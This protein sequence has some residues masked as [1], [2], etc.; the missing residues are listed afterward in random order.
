MKR[1]SFFLYLLLLS[2]TSFSQSVGT[3]FTVGNLRY[4]VLSETT[5][6]VD[7][8]SSFL[9]GHVS[10]PD[11]VTYNSNSFTVTEIGG[12]AF[13]NTSN[14]NIRAFTLPRTV[15]V[16]GDYA[17][18]GCNLYDSLVV[19]G[20]IASV[21]DNVFKSGI[22]I[23]RLDIYDQNAWW[24]ASF[25][26]TLSNPICFCRNF[27]SKGKP[28]KSLYINMTDIPE[29]TFKYSDFYTVIIG[30][31]VK[32]I[33]AGSF[34]TIYKTIWLPN[35]VPSGNPKRAEGKINHCSST[36]YTENT[37][38]TT[39]LYH[40]YP[41]LTSRFEV[42]GVIYA[43]LSNNTQCDVIDC[44]YSS[45]PISVNIGST[46]TYRGR[47]FN[48]RNIN[49]YACYEDECIT[50]DITLA[51]Q[52]DV[53]KYAFYSCRKA[54]GN[55]HLTNTGAIG[56]YAF[57]Y[58]TNM[59]GSITASNGGDIG[60]YAFFG[61]SLASSGEMNNQGNIEN[62]AF[63]NCS[64]LK[65][66]TVSNQGY[67][68]TQAFMGCTGLDNL[69]VAN[70][71]EIKREAFKSCNITQSATI[72]NN[73]H[74][75]G[76]AFYQVTGGFSAD[77]NNRGSLADSTFF[78]S[79]L[80]GLTIGNNVTTI[81][82]KCFYQSSATNKVTIE[83]SGEISNSA[84]ASMTGNFPI[85]IKSTCG[86]LP[87]SCFSYSKLSTISIGNAITTIGE[88][89]FYYSTFTS[90][91]IG[92]TVHTIKKNAFQ[93][94]TGFTT[95]TLPDNVVTLGK[96]AFRSCTTMQNI[97][98]SRGLSEI[99]EGTFYGCS[100]LKKI[101]IIKEINN[102]GDFVFNNCTRLKTVVFEDKSG[103]Y[104]L[105]VGGSTSDKKGLFKTCG[106]DSVYVGG[107]LKYATTSPTYS[108]FYSHTSLRSVRFTD[109]E[110]KIYP[111][112]FYS[113]TNLQNIWMGPTI[114]DVGDFAFAGCKSL[115]KV[116]VGP[117][118]I[119][120]G[121]NSFADCTA[122][123]QIN[124][125]NVVTVKNNTFVYCTSLQQINIPQSTTTIE[126]KVFLNCTSLKN[127]II[128]DRTAKLTLGIN[129]SGNSYKGITGAGT[130]L[131]SD[132]P[133]DSVYI[134]GPIS[135]TQT[136]SSG[137]SPFFYNESLRS[138][139]ITNK[140]RQVYTNEFYNCLGLQRIKLGSGVTKI[141]DLGFQSCTGLL[142]FEFASTLQS[143]GA[144][145]F[146]DC[147]H[148][149]TI[150]SHATIP[151]VVGEQGL[152]DINFWECTLYVPEG[153]EPDYREADQ[154]RNFF[155]ESI[156]LA[157]DITLDKTELNFYDIGETE[158]LT[159]TVVPS[160]VMDGSVTWSSSNPAVATVSEEGLVTAIANGSAVITA[161]TVDGTNLSA[162][163][164]VT[165]TISP[166]ITFADANVKTI[167]VA[168]W[169]TSHNGELSE[170]EAAAVTDIGTVFQNNTQIT[171]FDE[172]SYFTGLTSIASQAF[173][174]C[175]G[176]TSITIPE[177][178]TS[179]GMGAFK[180]CTGLTKAE[181][182]SVEDLCSMVFE[183]YDANPLV[184]AHH[185]YING[186]EI[187]ELVIPNSVTTIGTIAFRGCSSLTSATIPNSVTEIGVG[188][189]SD[190]TALASVSLPE[191]LTKISVG[192]FYGCKNLASIIIPEGV[193]SIGS[194]AFNGCSSLTS[195][196]VKMETPPAIKSTVF[197][198]RA[199]ATLY[200]PYGCSE[201][202]EATAYWNEFKK[203]VEM[204]APE[205][206]IAAKVG[207]VLPWGTEQ[208]WEM[209]YMF[210][211]GTDSEP[212]ADGSGHAWYEEEYDDESWETLSGP[213]ANISDWFSSVNTLW[214]TEGH[215]S[216]SY[217][218]RRTFHLDEVDEQGYTFLSQH[219]DDLK[220]WINGELV[221]D[222]GFDGTLHCHHIPASKFHE[223][224]NTL[225]I[226]INDFGGEAYLD[227][228]M[229][230]LFFL[231][232]V[233]TE[234]YLNAGNE[235][236]THAVLADEPLPV[237]LYKQLDGSYTI[238]FPVRSYNQHL[239][240]MD[241]SMSD[242]YVDYAG[243]EA[244]ACPYWNITDA[245]NGN[246][247]IQMLNE[248]D[249]YLGNDPDREPDNDVDGDVTSGKNVTWTLVPEGLHTQA[250]AERLQELITQANALHIDINKAQTV[251]D[252]ENS[253][254]TE[255]LAQ[256]LQVDGWINE[257]IWFEDEKVKELCVANWDRNEDGEL[258]RLEAGAVT[259]LGEVFK[260]NSEITS[261]NELQYFTR[262]T[263]ISD[264]AFSHCPSLETVVLPSTAI[265][266]ENI[267]EGCSKLKSVTFLNGDPGEKHFAN[268]FQGVPDDVL[269]VIPEGTA[270]NYL[271][272]GYRNLSDK[273]ALGKVRE[274]F[275]NQVNRIS[276]D[277]VANVADGDK[278]A[279]N[280]AISAAR[281]IVETA[282][283]YMTI[284][285]QIDAIKDAA[286]A[287]LATA[288]L[289]EDLDVTGAMITN[290]DNDYFDI[291]WTI[292]FLGVNNGW[293][294]ANYSNED[295][296][297]DSFVES[298]RPSEVLND[299]KHS[300]TIKNLPAGKYR[301][302][303]KAI[304]TWQDDPE[305]EVTGVCLFMGDQSTPLAT[306]NEK[307]QFFSVEF[308]NEETQDVEIGL[309]VENTTANW[310][311]LDDVR[312]YLRVGRL[313]GDANGDGYVTIAD[314]MAVVDYILGNT[315]KDFDFDAAN[316]NNDEVITIADAVSLVNMIL[317]MP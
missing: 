151:P 53:G 23:G 14:Q 69:T 226:S 225:A 30:P 265:M 64:G 301:L 17:F 246:Y 285:Q 284:Y 250:Q 148:V 13:Y 247:Y 261:F 55:I 314:V 8:S 186:E 62:Y 116:T 295:C 288:A 218:L 60:Q 170:A 10:I 95:I 313:P 181:F 281:E 24:E 74:I 99:L 72:T 220:V 157:T 291:G 28:V 152:E 124:L 35:V 244:S 262:L 38:L 216:S 37:T 200:V 131:F 210:F 67:I 188:I 121:Q 277:I 114:D 127:V 132:C 254:Y 228:S 227:Y 161:T 79:A 19:K 66:L 54:T 271:K 168:N 278:D 249:T 287:Y 209:K 215:E 26:A 149:K 84:F 42:G 119:Q 70:D 280:A 73:G 65:I 107:A 199:N 258:S 120:L 173:N 22:T 283:D 136:L 41:T 50:G 169:D 100:A 47:T 39:N 160:D 234:K 75:R 143:I 142:Y 94:A 311:A 71:G 176:L 11:T 276:N 187:T 61:C 86:I 87:T 46:V 5:V 177:N 179:I 117:A 80:K 1:L 303:V 137:Y 236:G 122:L 222:A 310:V 85:E 238:F 242:V 182:A 98:L 175:T 110:I 251:L 205:T 45:A 240:F 259:D 77:I 156:K 266:G 167:C 7:G 269:F 232:N 305:Q 178:I 241:E 112:E 270:E 118:V 108:P 76:C 3:I 230:H 212:E 296:T 44:N 82:L 213:I 196:Y 231:Q 102:I 174:G 217:C 257:G 129:T 297:I 191:N 43:L 150:I 302:D 32:T 219:D 140:E 103:N 135:Y 292:G 256:I 48:V 123:E 97:T 27:Y 83:N 294:D 159:A 214:N 163:C 93:N 106:L 111:N 56:D 260:G 194:S 193:T 2:S 290:P 105:G 298:W 36:A 289:T 243:Q 211:V 208:A 300:Q 92:T 197:S 25:G 293:Q 89:C 245:G 202:Y 104:N 315:P 253:T 141:N 63:Q 20:S 126:D 133:L 16:I 273:G 88:N 233:E 4:K 206:D 18:S 224:D 282:E 113:C 33:G 235:W 144:D 204:G 154:W 128:E 275:E 96:E 299:G 180:D 172:I 184:N 252:D 267:F 109:K 57:Y 166:K 263:S 207:M 286:K 274:L 6:S 158:T 316:V 189:F 306:A 221:V 171:S 34:K 139:Y 155:I 317:E 130:P 201:A 164:S 125:A 192:M 29:N 312:L 190:C 223:G 203:I 307:P 31:T 279:L 195:V 309:K 115:K 248:S 91:S 255:M 268:N 12:Y 229:G 81:G 49:D 58:C 90:I 51:N 198:N 134:G 40:V 147:N 68:G 237:Q 59:G 153:S 308:T 162:Q 183:D 138:V 9:S 101:T 15:S 304:A 78:G 146:S 272:R 21:G 239:L 165:V 185:L 145:A 264:E 52:G